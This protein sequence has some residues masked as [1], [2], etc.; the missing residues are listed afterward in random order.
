M[1]YWP[2]AKPQGMFLSAAASLSFGNSD[3]KGG[4]QPIQLLLIEIS[5]R[6]NDKLQ[7]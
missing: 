4:G 6:P 2:T 1:S 7:T 3:W 5:D